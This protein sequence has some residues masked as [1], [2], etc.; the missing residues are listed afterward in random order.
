MVIGGVMI[1]EGVGYAWNRVIRY[2][3]FMY[4][5]TMVTNAS[6]GALSTTHSLLLQFT[7]Y[8]I[9]KLA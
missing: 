1:G 7:N 4:N 8:Y 3:S 2:T 9:L 5:A 6:V